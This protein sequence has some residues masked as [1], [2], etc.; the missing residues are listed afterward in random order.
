[1]GGS[2]GWVGVFLVDFG[3]ERSRD[4]GESPC[5]STRLVVLV[6]EMFHSVC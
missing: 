5:E 2:G 4:V 3:V 1:M 6:E